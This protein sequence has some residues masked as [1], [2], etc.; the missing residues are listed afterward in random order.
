MGTT[1]TKGQLLR[2]YLRLWIVY[3]KR[4]D[5]SKQNPTLILL[6]TPRFPIKRQDMFERFLRLDFHLD[7]LLKTLQGCFFLCRTRILAQETSP[8]FK[9]LWSWAFYILECNREVSCTIAYIII[10]KVTRFLHFERRESISN[11]LSLV[12]IHR[13][14]RRY[15]YKGQI[16]FDYLTYFKPPP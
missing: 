1:E 14:T 13:E 15:F 16:I 2:P 6:L 9:V 3:C 4:D 10:W 7:K 5:C 12:P 8:S 11:P